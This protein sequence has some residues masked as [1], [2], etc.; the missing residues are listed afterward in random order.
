MNTRVLSFLSAVL[1]LTACFR[2]T[3]VTSPDGEISVAFSVDSSGVPHYQ[4]EAYGQGVISSSKLGLEAAE[5]ELGC[6]FEISDIKREKVDYQWTQPWGENKLMRD[7]HNEMAVLMKNS[8]GVE[9]TVRF[10]VFDDG[11]GYRYEYDATVAGRC[12]CGTND[13]ARSADP[14]DWHGALCVGYAA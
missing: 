13:R 5:A 2:N 12:R 10:R 4:V 9:L 14:L 3:D 7:H 11:L 6:G 8:Q 1:M